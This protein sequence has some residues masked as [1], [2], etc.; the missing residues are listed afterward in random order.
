MYVLYKLLWE[1]PSA[2]ANAMITVRT[3]RTVLKCLGKERLADR[4]GSA[5]PGGFDRSLIGRILTHASTARLI[6]PRINH[7]IACGVVR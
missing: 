6:D 1:D 5:R 3:V 2:S 7:V 4:L